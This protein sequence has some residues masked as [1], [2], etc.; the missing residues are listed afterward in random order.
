MATATLTTTTESGP[1]EGHIPGCRGSRMP[2]VDLHLG[3]NL[4]KQQVARLIQGQSLC[5]LAINGV[6]GVAGP[7]ACLLGWAAREGRDNLSNGKISE[8]RRTQRKGRTR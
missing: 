6:D 8:V 2:D 5:G 1:C 4:A 3:A 7:D